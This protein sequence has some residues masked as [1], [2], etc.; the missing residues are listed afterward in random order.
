MKRQKLAKY[1]A[2]IRD[3]EARQADLSRNRAGYMR[4]FAALAVLSLGGFFWNRWLGVGTLLTGVLIYVFG[5]YVV[6]MRARDYRFELEGL[7]ETTEELRDEL[8][9]ESAS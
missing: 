2:A 8:E 5:V 4:L 9:R 6:R 7:R 3:V 1:E